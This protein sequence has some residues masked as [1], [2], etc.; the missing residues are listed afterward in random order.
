MPAR[1]GRQL[2]KGPEWDFPSWCLF[3]FYACILVVGLVGFAEPSA[4][5]HR[6]VGIGYI[7]FASGMTM[8]S[9][10]ALVSLATGL[11]RSEAICLIGI[12]AFTFLHGLIVAISG[13]D[14]HSLV[15]GIRLMAAVPG[16]LAFAYYRSE[17]RLTRQ[18]LARQIATAETVAAQHPGGRDV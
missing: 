9:V 6:M 2:A 7:V 8:F 16:A 12:S 10:M 13:P 1:I 18:D 5:L 15:T 17:T 11:R 14:G 3:A 4:S